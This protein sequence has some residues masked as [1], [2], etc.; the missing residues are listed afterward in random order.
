MNVKAF[1][2]FVD[3]FVSA[4]FMGRCVVVMDNLPAANL[5]VIEPLIQ[6]ETAP[7]SS[8]Y[9]PILRTLIL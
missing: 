1:A 2:V 7:L 5:A 6:T 4:K 3:T 9:Y 8:I